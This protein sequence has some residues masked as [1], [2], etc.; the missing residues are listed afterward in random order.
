MIYL[1]N[2]W[3][4]WTWGKLLWSYIVFWNKPI[5]TEHFHFMYFKY[6]IFGWSYF[7]I[8]ILQKFKLVTFTWAEYFILGSCHFYVSSEYLL[9]LASSRF[10]ECRPNHK[11]C[12]GIAVSCGQWKN[13]P[14][15]KPIYIP[16]FSL[17]SVRSNHSRPRDHSLI[18][19]TCQDRLWSKT[20]ACII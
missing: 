10:L 17:P 11:L 3:C 5:C 15:G 14:W 12:F 18:R 13:R 20:T 16:S 8:F 4:W 9:H 19:G 7:C 6:S 2:Y 1:D